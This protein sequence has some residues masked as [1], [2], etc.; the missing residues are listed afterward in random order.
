MHLAEKQQSL[1]A[2]FRL[3]D[4]A[5]ERLA[6]IVARGKKWPGVPEAERID[7][8]RVPGCTSRVWLI[9]RLEDGHCHFQ[10]D[11]D[12]PL[13]KGLVALLC[14]LYDGATPGDI[15][16]TEPEIISALHLDRQIS[17]TRLNGLA[18]VRAMI[19][20]FAERASS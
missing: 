9:G 15:L 10:M 11:A 5:H 12:S 17:P 3:I 6:A 20:A 16:T 19:R 13:V 14:E 18:S 4:D 1:I 7:A 2:R 8:H